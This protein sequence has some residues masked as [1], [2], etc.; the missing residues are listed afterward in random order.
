MNSIPR[1]TDAPNSLHEETVQRLMK[2]IDFLEYD[3]ALLS[4][5]AAEA[6]TYAAWI[7][8]G[9]SFDALAAIPRKCKRAFFAC[10]KILWQAV[11][12]PFPGFTRYVRH[13]LF[14]K[15]SS[16]PIPVLSSAPGQKTGMHVPV[17]I[18]VTARN[19]ANF[20]QDCLES[21][22]RQTVTPL[23][24][25]Y[26]D[27]GSTDD[28]V[29]LATSYEGVRVLA[30]EHRGVA[31]ARNAAAKES[32]GAY[33]LFV[34]GDDMLTPDYVERQW[35]ALQSNPS[36]VFAYG[37]VQN[38]GDDTM[39]YTPEAWSRAKLWERNFVNTSSLMRRQAFFAVGG[40]RDKV[41][42]LWDWDLSL[43]LSRLG[44][45]ARSSA[46]LLYRRHDSS[47]SHSFERSLQADELAS[48]LGRARRS[49]ATLGVCTVYSGRVPELLPLWANAL[50]ASVA[51]AHLSAKPDVI[52]LDNS[53]KGMTEK[54]RTALE[55]HR[56]LF[57]TILIVPYDVRFSF[58]EEME[59]RDRVAEFLSTACN[60]LL[61]LTDADVVWFL[62]D[63]IIVPP[64][65]LPNLFKTLTDGPVAAV[66]GAYRSRHTDGIVIAHRVQDGEA[67]PVTLGDAPMSID[68][69][70]TGCLLMFRA[71]CPVPFTSHWHGD[72]AAHDWAWSQA[73]RDAGYKILLDPSVR[74]K[75]HT[76][77]DSYTE[78]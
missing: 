63:D 10:L 76:T 55:L 37:S 66:S 54:I 1:Q 36:A 20:L 48:L 41:G 53:P 59:R 71:L 58:T 68:L 21:I 24:V 73:A 77:S 47:W 9:K 3:A 6:R 50:A 25:L 56:N 40:W 23:E 26:C 8:L 16:L 14:R 64:H 38:F 75:H 29:A 15:K 34:D 78:V 60:R 39:F 72:T 13:E 45:G 35:N 5:Q 46:T 12:S 4:K 74:C 62:E 52:I 7:G 69:A 2:K 57:G 28:S 19:N 27:D 31:D 32:T 30:R 70:G 44:P 22:L 51:A 11:G 42:T 49:I 65:A 18:I 43:R 67:K 61:A 17:S 33:L